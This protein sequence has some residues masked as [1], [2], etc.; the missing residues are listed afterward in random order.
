MLSVRNAAPIRM[1]ATMAEVRTAPIRLSVKLA[2]FR[3][4]CAAARIS[5]PITPMA[6][7]SVGVA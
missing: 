7:A 4:P 5:A 3:L 6:A 1:K 2:Q